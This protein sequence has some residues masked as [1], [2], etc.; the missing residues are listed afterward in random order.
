[1]ED[2]GRILCPLPQFRRERL[3]LT[4]T[5]KILFAGIIL[6]QNSKFKSNQMERGMR[7]NTGCAVHTIRTRQM[8]NLH[9][10][11]RRAD[12]MCT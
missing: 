12:D 7:D 11:D 5:Q 3:N 9:R 4:T 6:L 10:R 2:V 1:M 8:S